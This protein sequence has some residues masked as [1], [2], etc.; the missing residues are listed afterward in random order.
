[1]EILWGRRRKMM[2]EKKRVE[3]AVMKRQA[4]VDT[5]GMVAWNTV[6]EKGRQG[7]E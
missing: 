2:K 7:G 4:L 5:I 3:E 6:Q 1:M